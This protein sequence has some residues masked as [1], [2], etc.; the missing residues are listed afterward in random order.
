MVTSINRFIC[1]SDLVNFKR[2]CLVSNSNPNSQFCR[3]LRTPWALAT[4]EIYEFA[5]CPFQNS[6]FAFREEISSVGPNNAWNYSRANWNEHLI[7]S[8]VT[9]VRYSCSTSKWMTCM[10][11]HQTH[12]HKYTVDLWTGTREDYSRMNSSFSETFQSLLW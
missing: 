12:V 5:K 11:I 6:V 1:L 9:G 2:K 10:G 3:K 4:W 7:I 8:K